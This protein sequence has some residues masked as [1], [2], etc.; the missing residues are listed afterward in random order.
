MTRILALL[1]LAAAALPAAADA[2][3]KT[4]FEFGR[5]GGSIRPFAVSIATTGR[6]T[7][8]GAAPEHRT[9]LTKKQLADLN[10][11]AFVTH[12]ETLPATTACPNTLPDIAAQYIRV[13]GRTVRVHGTCVTRFNR[14]WTALSHAA[15][16]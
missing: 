8:T 1:A 5:A 16:R 11:V 10:R 14:L 6:V 9:T 3:P 2:S 13:G 7:A 12:F 15:V 4:G